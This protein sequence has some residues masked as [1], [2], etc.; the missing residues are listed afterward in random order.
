M[1][2]TPPGTNVL[3]IL[4]DNMLNLY[5]M[6]ELKNFQLKVTPALNCPFSMAT[7]LDMIL[8]VCLRSCTVEAD[9][10]ATV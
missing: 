2:Y 5:Y 7:V 10:T 6:E 3:L 4:S 1:A 9:L 8:G